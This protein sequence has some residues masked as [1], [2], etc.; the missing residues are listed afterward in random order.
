MVVDF[1]FVDGPMMELDGVG[2]SHEERVSGL[3]PRHKPKGVHESTY[4]VVTFLLLFP[5]T[6]P[7]DDDTVAHGKQS[8][9]SESGGFV[10]ATYGLIV[11]LV[12]RFVAVWV[13]LGTSMP[14]T[15]MKFVHDV[16]VDVVPV[17]EEGFVTL[18]NHV[19]PSIARVTNVT[20]VGV[21]QVG[22]P[23]QGCVG[24]RFAL[25][26]P[27]TDGFGGQLTFWHVF[28]AVEEIAG[29]CN[30]D[31]AFQGI[32]TADLFKFLTKDLAGPFE[33]QH[34]GFTIGQELGLEIK[35]VVGIVLR[36]LSFEFLR[37]CDWHALGIVVLLVGQRSHVVL[38][39]GRVEK[40][41]EEPFLL[42]RES[43]GFGKGGQGHLEETQQVFEHNVS[44][45]DGQGQN[46]GSID[47]LLGH[48]VLSVKCI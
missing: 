4:G 47:D 27:T 3:E 48:N 11:Y 21:I 1:F 37:S 2:T 6:L 43:K 20:T 24:I 38:T 19:F 7:H 30:G 45:V 16:G 18:T 39:V 15:P 31:T 9:F 41:V 42:F 13:T 8:V 5:F 46:L 10:E 34:I 25:S 14:K 44:T 22:H 32:E 17:H 40:V 28:G 23:F 33:Q 29:G 35:D 26:M 12:T 36:I